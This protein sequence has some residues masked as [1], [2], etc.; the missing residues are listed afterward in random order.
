MLEG[1]TESGAE[2]GAPEKVLREKGEKEGRRKNPFS[3]APKGV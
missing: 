2:K 3:A 1:E